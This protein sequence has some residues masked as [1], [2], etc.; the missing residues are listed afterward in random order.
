MQTEVT[1]LTDDFFQKLRRESHPDCVVCGHQNQQGLRLDFRLVGDGIVEANFGCEQV[2]QG[3]PNILHGGV[4]CA[5]VDGAMANCLFA[6]GLAAV[7]ADLSVRFRDPVESRGSVTVRAWLESCVRP[8]H[9]VNA[10]LLQDGR[11]KV[12]AKGKFMERATTRLSIN[13]SASS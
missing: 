4:I 10:E 13:G 3:Y 6:H 12:I 5:L 8:L 7:T 9:K 1:Q 11:T 2:F